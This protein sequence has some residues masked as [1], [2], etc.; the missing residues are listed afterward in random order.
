MTESAA[1]TNGN[2]KSK[3]QEI[4]ADVAVIGAGPAG[5]ALATYLARDGRKVVIFEREKFPRFRIGE[6]LLPLNLQLFRELGVEAELE[7]RFIRKY[8]ANFCD[9]YGGRQN[10]YPFAA[11]INKN[12]PY[13]YQVERAELDQVLLDN[14]EK[15]GA[16]VY[17]DWTVREVIYEGSR[18]VGVIAKSNA[19]GTTVTVRCKVVAD[20]SGRAAFCGS[21]QKLKKDVTLDSR[22]A[23]FSHFEGVKRDSG[24]REGDI[25]IVAFPHGWFWMIP[26]KGNTTSV[27]MVVTDEYLKQRNQIAAGRPEA[28]GTHDET[29]GAVA[30]YEDSVNDAFLAKTIE[31]TPYV[32]DR[33]K[34]A[35]QKFPSRSIPNFSYVMDRY[36]G[37]GFVMVGDS[38]AFLDPVFSSGVFLTMKSAQLV[39]EDLRRAFRENDFSAKQFSRYEERIRGAQAVFL[40][41]IQGWYDP[42]FLDLFFFPRNVLGLKTAITSVLAADL[43]DPR[44]LWSLKLRIQ[45]LFSIAELHRWH[46]K[47]TNAGRSMIQNQVL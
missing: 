16:T 43:F 36:S 22:T 10:R 37:D 1:P 32:R 3:A 2:G 9:Q 6:S 35:K 17:M 31:N 38:G 30:G 15:A 40:K 5:S 34:E 19:D 26:F 47:K 45:L 18:A 12:Y 21:R 7:K 44:H 8:A 4:I 14:A 46:M 23:F 25:Q 28:R 42:A 39:A 13:C 41:F 33:M 24:D 20:C 27:G 29:T 11:A